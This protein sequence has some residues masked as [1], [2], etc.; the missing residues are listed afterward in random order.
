VENLFTIA[1]LDR[2]LVLLAARCQH[3]QDGAGESFA[4]ENCQGSAGG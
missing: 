1:D 2:R 3:Q 4:D